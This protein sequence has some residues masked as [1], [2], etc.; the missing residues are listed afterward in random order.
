MSRNW[1][2]G[3]A[4]ICQRVH[5]TEIWRSDVRLIQDDYG[6]IEVVHLAEYLHRL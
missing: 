2:S 6:R 3:A 4:R 1:R 5:K